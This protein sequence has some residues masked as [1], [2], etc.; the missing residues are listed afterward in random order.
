MKLECLTI[1]FV[2][3]KNYTSKTS[4]QSRRANEDLLARFAGLVKPMVRAFNGTVVKALGDAFLISFKSPTD[5]LL[6]AMAV[7]D[8]LHARNA[9]WPER[10]RFQLRFAI[11]AGEVRVDRNDVFGEAVNVAA[12]IEGLADGGEIYFSEI[13]YLMMNRS[14]VPFKEVGLRKL[15]G[16]QKSVR[17]YRVPKLREVG[18]YKL[19]PHDDARGDASA[20]HSRPLPFGGLA[21]KRVRSGM[22]ELAE[23]DGSFYLAQALAE[24]HYKATARAAR[25]KAGSRGLRVLAPAHYLGSLAFETAA[26]PFSPATYRGLRTRLRADLKQIR[27]SGAHRAKL[28]TRL[29]M[30]ALLLTAVLFAW[31]RYMMV[32]QAELKAEQQAKILRVEVRREEVRKVSPVHVPWW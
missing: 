1:V 15:K 28:F 17:V 14:E 26:L 22:A 20:P 8:H 10:E 24:A 4:G 11:N 18:V 23:T 12:R 27:E 29:A 19:A 2:D 30:L 25:F 7:Q 5:S 6:C 9:R 13:V 3:I 16:I 32:Q 21:L 31:K